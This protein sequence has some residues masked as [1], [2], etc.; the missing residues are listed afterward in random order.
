MEVLA[1]PAWRELYALEDTY[2]WSAVSTIESRRIFMHDEFKE[3]AC[4]FSEQTIGPSLVMDIAVYR[5]KG[6]IWY[7]EILSRLM[8]VQLSGFRG[9]YDVYIALVCFS[10]TV[11]PR[12]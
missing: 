11:L 12:I 2:L 8:E 4:I 10:R 5:M 1:S 6:E 7:V 9:K 3:L